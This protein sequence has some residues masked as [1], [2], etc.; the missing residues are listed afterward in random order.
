ME[1]ISS[2]F[3]SRVNEMSPVADCKQIVTVPLSYDLDK[4]KCAK[5]NL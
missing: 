2:K 4:L 3:E 5:Q 1:H